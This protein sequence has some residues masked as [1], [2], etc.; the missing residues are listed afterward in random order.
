MPQLKLFKHFVK[1]TQDCR[2]SVSTASSITSRNQ[3][4]GQTTTSKCVRHTDN[5]SKHSRPFSESNRSNI[6]AGTG[7]WNNTLSLT[8]KF[9]DNNETSFKCPTDTKHISSSARPTTCIKPL[10]SW[11]S[12]Q[13]H[14][15][16]SHLSTSKT[17][18]WIPDWHK[19]TAQ[20]TSRLLQMQTKGPFHK[21][22]STTHRNRALTKGNSLWI[23]DIS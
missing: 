15:W 10:I 8:P 19:A 20:S 21:K 6:N 11:W 13:N 16:T 3:F 23:H 14:L 12:Q 18:T 7:R 9:S 5:H 22:L 2:I 1:K 4:I 17:K